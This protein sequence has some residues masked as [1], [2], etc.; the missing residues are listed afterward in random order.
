M[1]TAQQTPMM[2]QYAFTPGQ[3]ACQFFHMASE[4]GDRVPIGQGAHSG[5]T[6]LAH[7]LVNTGGEFTLT[8]YDGVDT[9]APVVAS[10]TNPPT[11]AV[12]SFNCV[13]ERGLACTFTGTPG[14]VTITYMDRAR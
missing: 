6:F 11:G 12:F 1:S 14:D 3:D 13:A 10:I 7:V 4:I 5:G 9:M 2:G 8:L